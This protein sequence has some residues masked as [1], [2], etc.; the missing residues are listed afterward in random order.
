MSASD[1]RP[2]SW[3]RIHA[4]GLPDGS[5]RA[6]LAVGLFGTI[7]ALLVMAPE[8]SIPDY[9]RNLLFIIMGHYF[10]TRRR[11]LPEAAAGPGPLFLPRGTI[12]WVLCVGFVVVAVL[13]WR[14]GRIEDPTR[15]A[16]AIL[17]LVAGFL[18]GVLVARFQE[19]RH[20]R[21]HPTPRWVEDARA[22]MALI[23]AAVLIVLVW[24]KAISHWFTPPRF[25][26]G[27]YGIEHLTSAVV[28]FYFGS[29]S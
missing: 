7:W 21:G 16:T 2:E 29:R 25:V 27:T 20:Q 4:F 23:A 1:T 3:R 6:I 19:W 5:V 24:N 9:L 12:R 22:A 13:L 28:G 26:V 17:I 11:L 18:L 10:A 15:G 14:D 8:E